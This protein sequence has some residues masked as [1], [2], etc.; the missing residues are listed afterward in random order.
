MTRNRTIGTFLVGVG[1]P[2]RLLLTLHSSEFCHLVPLQQ[3]IPRYLFLEIPGLKNP[4]SKLPPE[5]IMVSPSL[6]D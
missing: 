2:N 1:A 5:E 3:T 4:I 6:I